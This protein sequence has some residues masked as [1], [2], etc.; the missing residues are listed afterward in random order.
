MSPHSVL[1]KPGSG[2]G[3]DILRLMDGVEFLS[4][5]GLGFL[6]LF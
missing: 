1:L 4:R 5:R 2:S 6:S 3:A